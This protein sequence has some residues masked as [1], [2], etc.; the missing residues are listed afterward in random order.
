MRRAA[1]ALVIAAVAVLGGCGEREESGSGDR[2]EG[3]TVALDWFPN[4]DHAGIYAGIDR[5]YFEDAGL[6]LDPQVPSDPAAP[7]KQVAAGRVD[8][9]ISYEPEVLLAREEGLDVVAV[10]ALARTP[11]TS[12]ASLGKDAIANPRQLD[13]KRVATAGIPYQDA[14]LDAILREGGLRPDDVEQVDVGLNLLSPLIARRVDAV[15]GLFWNIEGVQ[16]QRRG[17]KPTVIPVDELGIPTYDELV[18]V[19]SADRV[20]DDP[21][22]V[23]LFL[24]ALERGTRA[25]DD[26]PALATR[27]LVSAN[28][29]L[30]PKLTRA[31]V[32]KTLPALLPRG[33]EPYG[34]MDP[35]RWREFAG[36]MVDEGVLASLPEIDDVLTNELLPGRIPE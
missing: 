12:L 28:R 5:G 27:A 13:G 24:A 1:I 16:L 7:I 30:D 18:L 11:L 25:A 26:D 35:A 6:D 34:R 20:A 4:P 9:A 22:A 21:E 17:D 31:Q 23:R 33:G 10:G 15:L 36:F 14:F 3:F 2:T 32:S 19:A 8:L 29:D